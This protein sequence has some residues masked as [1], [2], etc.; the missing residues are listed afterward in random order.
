MKYEIVRT[1][2]I[3]LHKQ[4]IEYKINHNAK[5]RKRFGLT[6]FS[7]DGSKIRADS[8]SFLE[9]INREYKLNADI[10]WSKQSKNNEEVYKVLALDK[11]NDTMLLAMGLTKSEA[12]RFIKD[13]PFK[14]IHYV[15]ESSHKFVYD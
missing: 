6:K 14:G 8:K 13:H 1:S 2:D 5:L 9:W 10:P 11:D 12:Y 3:P 15:K 7:I 4:Q